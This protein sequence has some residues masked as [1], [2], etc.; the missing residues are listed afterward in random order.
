MTA[1]HPTF[2]L[3]AGDTWQFDALLH[4]SDGAALDL[5]DAEIVWRLRNSSQQIV[6][7]LSVGAGIAL[8]APLAGSCR[9]TLPVTQT[10]LLPA[11]LYSDETWV[12]TQAGFASTQAVGTIAVARAGQTATPNLAGELAALKAARRSGHL[13]VR[14]ENFETEYKSDAEM[15]RAITALENEIARGQGALPIRNVYPRSTGWS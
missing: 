7:T 5:T 8:I 9:I 14:I 15:V 11:G 10:A 3:Y 12:R 13:R 1:T 6:E 4:D 2:L